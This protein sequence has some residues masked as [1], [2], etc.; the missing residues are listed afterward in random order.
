MATLSHETAIPPPPEDA[1]PTFLVRFQ[2][3]LWLWSAMFSVA[4]LFLAFTGYFGLGSVGGNMEAA[5]TN[6]VAAIVSGGLFGIVSLL[7]FGP[8]N[9]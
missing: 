2:R 4:A 8:A 3:F 7:K 5:G 6:F 9:A 1:E